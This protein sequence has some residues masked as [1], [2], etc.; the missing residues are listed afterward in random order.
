LPEWIPCSLPARRRVRCSARPFAV[1]LLLPDSRRIGRR[2]GTPRAPVRRVTRASR[3]AS[4]STPGLAPHTRCPDLPAGWARDRGPMPPAGRCAVRSRACGT[5]RPSVARLP[6]SGDRGRM[7]P[8]RR[9]FPARTRRSR[10]FARA[11]VGGSGRPPR[12]RFG[13]RP[14]ASRAAR[15]RRS[16]CRVMP[17]DVRF[18]S[19]VGVFVPESSRGPAVERPPGGDRCRSCSLVIVFLVAGFHAR[20]GPPSPFSAALAVSPSLHFPTCFSR[21]RPWGSVRSVQ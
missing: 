13:W 17:A 20:F 14:L 10:P 19:P 2:V 4:R 12:Y 1:V 6:R 5:H 11:A 7:A 18:P 9:P 21:T 16:G 3:I 15:L 8:D